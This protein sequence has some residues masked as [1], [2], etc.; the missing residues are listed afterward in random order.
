NLPGG[1]ATYVDL[2]FGNSFLYVG[3][4]LY[5]E[6]IDVSDPADPHIAGYRRGYQASGPAARDNLIFLPTGG[7]GLTVLRNDLIT[8]IG[9][10]NHVRVIPQFKLHQNFPN[11]FNVE[12]VISYQIAQLSHVQLNIY[13]ILGQKIKTLVNEVQEQGAHEITL[14]GTGLSSG[15]YFYELKTGKFREVKSA[16]LIK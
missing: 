12:T 5:F 13:N 16:L 1:G 15:I 3:Y 2:T 14:D 9:T 7:L 10:D 6:M 4:N 11:P 8:S